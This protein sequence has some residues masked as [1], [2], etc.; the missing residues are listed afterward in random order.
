MHAS[1]L[2]P[3]SILNGIN[4]E[5]LF[6]IFTYCYINLDAYASSSIP[7]VQYGVSSPHETDFASFLLWVSLFYSIAP[8]SLPLLCVTILTVHGSKFLY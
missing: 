1:G 2:V 3:V 5:Y 4:K 6:F 8:S 7:V